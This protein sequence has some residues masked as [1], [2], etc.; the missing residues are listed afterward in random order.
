MA[1][2][3]ECSL[4][5]TEN[6]WPRIQNGSVRG[7]KP[8]PGWRMGLYVYSPKL[9]STRIWRVGEW[10]SAPLFIRS[11]NPTGAS[12]LHAARR[13]H[14]SPASGDRSTAT[15]GGCF[16]GPRLPRRETARAREPPRPYW[17]KPQQQTTG[18]YREPRY[19]CLRKPSLYPIAWKHST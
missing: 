10:L 5:K 17:F 15:G 16:R 9:N 19:P 6:N 1:S 12:N 14:H 11:P 3:S 13:H 2:C 7:E 4:A 8:S 18:L